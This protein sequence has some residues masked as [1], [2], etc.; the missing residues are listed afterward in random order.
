MSR[1]IGKKPLKFN[2]KECGKEQQDGGSHPNLAGFCCKACQQEA[3]RKYVIVEK[4]KLK[5]T[6]E[7][8]DQWK[9]YWVELRMYSLKPLPDPRTVK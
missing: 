6:V 4:A 9:A 1:K 8:S 7:K 2:C 5:A 3:K